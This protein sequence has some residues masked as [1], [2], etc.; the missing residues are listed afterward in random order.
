M[1][2]EEMQDMARPQHAALQFV[3]QV[4]GELWNKEVRREDLP[5]L[6]QLAVQAVCVMEAHLPATELDI[7]LHNTVH[8][9]C[10]GLRA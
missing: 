4:I 8:L 9:A 10:D 2:V 5:W 6:G 3:L 1:M 7:K